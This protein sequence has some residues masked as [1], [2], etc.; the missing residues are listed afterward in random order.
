M[1]VYKKVQLTYELNYQTN[2]MEQSPSSEARGHLAS[3]EIPH[4]L[5]N[6]RIRKMFTRTRHWSLSWATWIQSTHFHPISL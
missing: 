2:S 3:Q 4:L 5:L 1:E 6:R